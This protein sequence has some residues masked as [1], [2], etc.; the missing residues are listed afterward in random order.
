[1]EEIAIGKVERFFSKIGVAAIKI[2][3]GELKVGDTIKFKGHSTDFEQT[4]ESMQVE[5]KNVEKAV[6]GDDI[7]IKVKEK[8]RDHDAVYLVKP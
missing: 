2:T 5:H 4:V 1:M 7:G 6:A 3:S 8:V